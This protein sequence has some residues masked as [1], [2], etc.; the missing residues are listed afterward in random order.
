MPEPRILLKNCGR[1]DPLSLADYEQAGGF[2]A[3][4]KA[5]KMSAPGVIEAVKG[6]DL[7]GRGGAGFRCGVKWELAAEAESDR[8]YFICNADEGEV[9]AFKDRYLI[10]NDPFSIIE[11]LGIGSLAIGATQ[12]YIYLRREYAYLR[13][14]LENAIRAS[15]RHLDGLEIEIREG[16]GSYIC[17]EESALMSSIEGRRGEPRLKPP[18]PAQ[19]GL[20]GAPTII[21][22]VETLVNLAPI[23]LNG[24]DWYRSLGTRESSG[25]KLFSVSGDVPRPGVYELELGTGLD[26]LVIGRAGAEPE[27]IRMVQLGGASGNILPAS[28]L[29]TPLAFETVL[30]SGSVVVFNQTRDVIDTVR[31]SVEFLNEESCGQCTPCREGTEVMVEIFNR[32]VNGQGAPEDIPNLEDLSQAMTLSSRCGLGQ[33]APTPVLDSLRHFGREYRSRINQAIFLRGLKTGAERRRAE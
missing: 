30:G 17:G 20:F 12:A 13:P 31:R 4:A 11:G 7:R 19:S 6:A 23:I 28:E 27:K 3:L 24:P 29:S 9:G 14:I 8:K 22:N 1:I 15:A 21:N 5:R 25:T 26:E 33:A 32:L 10:Q 2:K 18:Y 16:A